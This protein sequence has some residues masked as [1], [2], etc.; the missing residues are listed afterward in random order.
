MTTLEPKDFPQMWEKP[1]SEELLSTL[2]QLELSP[3]VWSH[4]RRRSHIIH[5][6][7]ATA[8]FRREVSAYLSSVI[9]SGLSWIQDDDE[10]DLIWTE[11]SRR[12]SERCGRAGLS[13]A[14][15]LRPR[16][17]ILSVPPNS[18]VATP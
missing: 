7:E 6:L 15:T 9:K 12:I 17:F 4:T 14:H 1:S 8:Y 5:E 10:K 13:H 11:A 18:G 2:R 16:S 3:P